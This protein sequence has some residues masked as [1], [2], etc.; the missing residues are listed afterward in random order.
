MD[1][2]Q[3]RI[4]VEMEA[5]S[6]PALEA[7]PAMPEKPVRRRRRLSVPRKEGSKLKLERFDFILLQLLKEGKSDATELRAIF[8]VDEK[9]FADRLKSLAEGSYVSISSDSKSIFLSLRGV[10]GYLLKWKRAADEW[11]GRKE[12]RPHIMKEIKVAEEGGPQKVQETKPLDLTHTI[13][14]KLPVEVLWK[15]IEQRHSQIQELPEEKRREETIDIMELMR[16]FGPTEEQKHLLKRT[17]PFVERHMPRKEQKKTVGDRPEFPGGEQ[18]PQS[19][20]ANTPKPYYSRAV[21]EMAK[22]TEESSDPGENCELC[23]TGFIISVKKE[24]HNPKYG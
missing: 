5:P 18:T 20:S 24:E 6:E 21:S 8:N 16:K 22:K 14:A 13:Q 15:E 2:I 11:L 9:E 17:S 12:R 1:E 23:K 3:E 4:E 19:K 7:A 10:N